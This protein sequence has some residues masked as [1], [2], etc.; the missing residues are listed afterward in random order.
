MTEPHD[1]AFEDGLPERKQRR[2]WPRWIFL[3][4]GLTVG[5]TLSLTYTW[6]VNP[7]QYYNTDPVDL[8]QQYKETWITLIAAAYRQDGDLDR[9]LSRLAALE[10]PQ[11][12]RTVADLTEREIDAGKPA[13]R[14]RA[15]TGLSDALGARTEKMM[16]YL[17]TPT[18]VLPTHTATPL[19]LPSNTPTASATPTPTASATPTLTASAT[20]TDTPT[21]RPTITRRPTATR[22]P[23]YIVESRQRICQSSRP[24]PHIQIVVQTKDGAGI[25]GSEIWVTWTGGADRFLTGLKPDLGL[26]Y[27]DFDMTPGVVYA[28]AVGDPA[29]PIVSGLSAETCRRGEGGSSLASWRLV[30]VATDQAFT[31]TPT[32]TITPTE[33]ATRTARPTFTATA[34]PAPSP[35]RT[36]ALP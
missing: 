36:R 10:D 12:G 13:T 18:P 21:P 7:V 17:A 20:P 30:I 6:V 24:E 28:V 9:A 33:A 15:L 5:L 3:L 29:P 25:P 14:V 23:P 16:I 8:R 34:T 1:T 4:L 31:P 2:H 11:I 22:P 35:T 32:P 26:G 27:A 19:P